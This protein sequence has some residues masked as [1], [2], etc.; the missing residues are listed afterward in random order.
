MFLLKITNKSFSLL[1]L[2]LKN[3]IEYLSYKIKILEFTKKEV[4]SFYSS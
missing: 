3:R 1:N 2:V 4:F